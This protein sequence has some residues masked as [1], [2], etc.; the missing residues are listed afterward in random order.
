MLTIWSTSTNFGNILGQEFGI[1]IG[2]K[3]GSWVIDSLSFLIIC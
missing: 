3:E 1:I 2:T